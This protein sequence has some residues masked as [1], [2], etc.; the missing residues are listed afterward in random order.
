M[1][2]SA[3]GKT[4]IEFPAKWIINSESHLIKNQFRHQD[5]NT[6]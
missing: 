3:Q 4:R 5:T 1:H 2:M 6:F